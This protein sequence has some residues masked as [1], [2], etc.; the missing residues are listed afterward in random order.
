[1]YSQFSPYLAVGVIDKNG[2]EIWNTQ[3]V[4]M[5]HI[6]ENG[7]L[8]GVNGQGVQFNYDEQIIW[9]TPNGTEI[10]GH[11]VKQIPNGNYMA[12]FLHINKVQYPWRLDKFIPIFWLCSGWYNE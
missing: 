10:D 1:M 4:Y 12:L 9:A 3:S 6:N 2:N 8:Y 7:Q 5:N 11:E